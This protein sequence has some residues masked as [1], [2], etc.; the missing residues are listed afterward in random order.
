MD[1]STQDLLPDQIVLLT[2]AAV[3]VSV[4]SAALNNMMWM[5]PHRG[6]VVEFGGTG[7]YHYANM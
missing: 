6:A 5:R 2:R 3:V 4:H 1:L 7:N